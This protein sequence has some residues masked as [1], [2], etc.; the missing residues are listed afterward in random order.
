MR[1]YAGWG[2]SALR[3]AWP[4]RQLIAAPGCSS[5]AEQGPLDNH[6]ADACSPSGWSGGSCLVT[7]RR[8][9]P[10]P[11]RTGR[12]VSDGRQACGTMIDAG[13]VL[14][15]ST[16][17]SPLSCV[18][19]LPVTGNGGTVRGFQLQSVSLGGVGVADDGQVAGTVGTVAGL[20]LPCRVRIRQPVRPLPT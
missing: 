18:A 3:S 10:R 19:A 6:Y 9:E 17:G 2:A 4:Q 7:R 11:P 20:R 16:P 8:Q 1:H 5:A 12:L 15:D 14:R 13:R